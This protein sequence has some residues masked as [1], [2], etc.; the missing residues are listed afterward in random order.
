MPARRITRP[1]QPR[2]VNTRRP[3]P[4]TTAATPAA[5][6]PPVFGIDFTS[7]PRRAKPITIAR[8][9][10]ADDAF[11]LE[12]IV[13][14]ADWPAYERWLATPGPWVG[15]FDFPFGLP[16]EAVV[17]LGWP[18]SWPALV[19]HCADLDRRDF[20]AALDAYRETRAV[21]NRYAHRATDAPARS[22]SPLKLVNPPVALMFVEGARRLV[23]A[24][25]TVPT[26][27][28]GDGLRVALE[29][30]PGLAAR[31]ITRAPYKS[32]DRAKQT[33]ERRASRSTIVATLRKTGGPFGF[34]LAGSRTL[35]ASLVADAS[36]D[37]LDAA[38]AA[39]QA[40]WGWQRRADGWGLPDGVDPLEGWI[41]MA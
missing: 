9:R 28:A 40:A 21:G 20:R 2:L 41:V 3:G 18:R 19:R 38:I 15:G 16:R 14:C 4:A 10:L 33:P 13:T 37:R 36:G 5:A 29:A 39:M 17:D 27:A 11:V 35:L 1:Q 34:T 8:G 32:D 6:S 26:L 23:A 22:H 25:V 24:G 30:Y 31:A 12:E 7:A